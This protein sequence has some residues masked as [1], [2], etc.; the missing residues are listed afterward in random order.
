[1]AL[2]VTV[3][4]C[5]GSY[6]GPGQACSGYLVRADG[7]NVVLDLGPGALANLQHHIGLH[8]VDAVV[9]SHSHPDHWLDLSGLRTATKYALEREGLAVYGT[10]ENRKLAESIS[11]GGLNPTIDWH[12]I[13]DGDELAIGGLRLRFSETE[14]YVETLAVR[15]DDPRAGRS[16]AYS[17]DTGPGWALDRLG[18]GIDLVLCEATFATDE[19]G[20]GVLHL[21][22]RQAGAMAASAGARRLVLTHLWP[23]GDPRRYERIGSEAFG[24]PVELA[25]TGARYEL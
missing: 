13:H 8:E 18:R 21:S 2:S 4:G 5:S 9:L 22:A 25:R 7:V 14:H 17:A 20:E 11:H 3:L 23:G 15:V 19:E 16:I 1:M 24:E 10:A 6:P 12:E